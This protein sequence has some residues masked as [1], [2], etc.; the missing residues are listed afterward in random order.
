MYGMYQNRQDVSKGSGYEGIGM[1]CFRTEDRLMTK[2]VVD[3]QG[4]L[5]CTHM[6]PS[7]AYLRAFTLCANHSDTLA[8]RT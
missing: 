6:C 8:F 3:N 7:V 1:K 5:L 4:S 2:L